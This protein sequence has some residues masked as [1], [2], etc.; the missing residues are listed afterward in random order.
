MQLPALVEVAPWKRRLLAPSSLVVYGTHCLGMSTFKSGSTV[1][2][3]LGQKFA[4]EGFFLAGEREQET[5]PGLLRGGGTEPGTEVSAHSPPVGSALLAGAGVARFP[6]RRVCALC[7]RSD[8]HW[9]PPG[10]SL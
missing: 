1:L 2:S 5:G 10:A 4:P 8:L 9:H 6:P 7:G 3:C